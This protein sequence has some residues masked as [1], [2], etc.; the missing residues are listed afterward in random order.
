M[1]CYSLQKVQ[2]SAWALRYR[3]RYCLF[4]FNLYSFPIP[5]PITKEKLR[6]GNDISS[7]LQNHA[8]ESRR[9]CA[10]Q[11]GLPGMIEKIR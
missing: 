4:A 8:G 3:D 7:L 2:L 5:V 6:I 11:K 9:M 1:M 10:L